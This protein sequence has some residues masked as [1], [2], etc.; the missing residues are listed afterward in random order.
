M[1][2]GQSWAARSPLARLRDQTTTIYVQ[3]EKHQDMATGVICPHKAMD[4][5]ELFGI[6]QREMLSR[7]VEFSAQSGDGRVVNRVNGGW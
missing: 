4:Q 1:G 7:V 3:T 2:L 6:K 5:I